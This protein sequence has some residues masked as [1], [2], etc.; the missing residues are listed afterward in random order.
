MHRN[1]RPV[2]SNRLIAVCL[3]A[4]LAVP[5][6]IAAAAQQA[7]PAQQFPDAPALASQ[8]APQSSGAPS[9][10]LLS[11]ARVG[12]DKA[13]SAAVPVVS[14]TAMAQ[15]PAAPVPEDWS[16]SQAQQAPAAQDADQQNQ[17]QKPVGTAAGPVTRPTGVAGARPSGAAIAPAKQRR[18]HAFY[19]RVGIIVAAAAATGAVIALSH[20][21]P[22]RP[23]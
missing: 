10:R 22:A 16:L 8:P 18:V 21:S 12:N 4:L 6:P 3:S 19:F 1:S 14:E 9:L 5:L 17:P 13:P 15:P 20:A 11:G 23:Q 2:L 7:P